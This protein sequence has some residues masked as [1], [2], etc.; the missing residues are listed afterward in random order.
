[1]HSLRGPSGSGGTRIRILIVEDSADDAELMARELHRAAYDVTWRRVD[2]AVSMRSALREQSW[3]V[4]L[5]DF[6][7][8]HFSGPAAL[9]VAQESRED[10]PFIVVSSSI[11]EESAVALMRAGAA[12]YIFKD[13]LARLAPC[14]TREL[15]EAKARTRH[16]ANLQR[17]ELLMAAVESANDMVIVTLAETSPDGYRKIVYAN[18]AVERLTGW[19]PKELVGSTVRRFYGPNAEP[20]S[21]PGPGTV[22]EMLHS[23]KDGS[24]F[25]AEVS[26]RPVSNDA[27]HV[28][29]WLSVRRDISERKQAEASLAYVAHY[30][31]LTGLPNRVLLG[32]QLQRAVLEARRAHRLAAVLFIDLDFF[33]HVNDT[34]GHVEGDALLRAV[35]TRLR[36]CVREGD[37]LCRSGA[38]EFVLLLERLET[39]EACSAKAQSV[40][41]AFVEPFKLGGRDLYVTASIGISRYPH[42]AATAEDL[43]R[44]AD[45]AMYQAK[46]N[47]RNGFQFYESHMRARLVERI[48]LRDDL[49]R[50]LERSEFELHYQPILEG[51]TLRVVAAE[52]LVRWRHPSRGLV[53][54]DQFIG[55][56]EESGLIVPLGDWVLHRACEQ[57]AAW[58]RLRRRDLRIGVNLSAR[59]LRQTGLLQTIKSTLAD[60]KLPP[61]SLVVE[62]TES[63]FMNDVSA[64]NEI[65]SELRA[66]GV[67]VSIDDFGT[68]YSS[69]GYLKTLPIDSIKIDRSFVSGLSSDAFDQAIA[70]TIVTLAHAIRVDAV[71]EGV[72]TE[73]QLAVLRSLDCDLVQGFLFSKPVDAATFERFLDAEWRANASGQ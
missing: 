19:K 44:C 18:S 4:I 70:R 49:R 27:G 35:A 23:R 73:Q 31:A 71:A 29:H 38:D 53:P 17:L 41:N 12:D 64:A 26:S 65:L 52:A 28:T 55:A 72:E 69:L 20:E 68:G 24:S 57:A 3:D 37:T 14:V 54:P 47:G 63:I 7:M 45:T 56:A 32:D 62:I 51:A 46:D 30:D 67:R 59:Q 15:R 11:G 58:S 61:H 50:A 2:D 6:N 10:I 1:M 16:R 22:P 66:T 34:L 43:M 36:G 9:A 40:L 5:S 39:A 21:E 25:W 33:K 60:S 48:A 42:D 13:K 8:P